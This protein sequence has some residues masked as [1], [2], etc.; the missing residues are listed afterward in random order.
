MSMSG[1][2]PHPSVRRLSLQ[3]SGMWQRQGFTLDLGS[4]FESNEAEFD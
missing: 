3:V 2:A 4:R 1:S